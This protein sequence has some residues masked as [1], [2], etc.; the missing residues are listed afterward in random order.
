M[1]SGVAGRPRRI[2]SEE[3]THRLTG[4]PLSD[5]DQVRVQLVPG[6]VSTTPGAKPFT[7]IPCG[8]R[9]LAAPWMTTTTANFAMQ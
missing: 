9:A 5:G 1:S 3:V 2:P 8:A 4:S 6:G 7:R